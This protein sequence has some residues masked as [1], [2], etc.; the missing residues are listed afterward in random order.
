LQLM[1]K[2]LDG[3]RAMWP[4]GK[5]RPKDDSALEHAPG[6][7]PWY[8]RRPG[9]EIRSGSV[10]L[11]WRDA[12]EKAPF[13]GKMCLVGPDGGNLAVLDF[14][15]YVQQLPSG[16]VILWHHERADAV[17]DKLRNPRIHFI[18]LDPTLL[19]PIGDLTTACES[20]A[21]RHL[22]VYVPSGTVAETWV[23]AALPAGSYHPVFPDVMRE[24]DELL[25][26]AVPELDQLALYVINAAH[27]RIE[28]HPQD[29]FN[30]ANLD[31][32]YQWVTRVARE[33][34]TGRIQ[35]EGFRIDPFVLDATHRRLARAAP[36][37]VAAKEASVCAGAGL[38]PAADAQ[39]VR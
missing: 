11:H 38:E 21:A 12:D 5:Q 3:T 13:T 16:T 15:C 7:S 39:A 2:S 14:G 10:T 9:T 29:W 31:Y 35:G 23:S 37:D 18:A 32:G 4:F 6:P 19:T 24:A 8:L 1:R 26:L 22:G 36:S 33:P 27:G 34:T 17:N 20:L 30:Q 25:V 28:V